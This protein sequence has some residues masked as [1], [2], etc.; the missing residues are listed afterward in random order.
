L[1]THRTTEL[2]VEILLRPVRM[3]DEPLL[4]DFFY[5]LSDK[6]L[7]RRFISVRQDMPHERLQEFVAIDYTQEMVILAVIQKEEKEVIVGVG[8]FGIYQTLHTAEVAFAVRDDFQNKGIGTELLSYLTLLAKKQG[9]LGFYAEV[10]AENKP[11]L[12]LFEK[13]GFDIKKR[14]E[15]GVDELEMTF[16]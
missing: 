14:R 9:L 11:M 7:Y 3:N 16:R 10:L 8:Q 4:K 13:M 2:G 1:E 12:H 5:S 6:S 15:E